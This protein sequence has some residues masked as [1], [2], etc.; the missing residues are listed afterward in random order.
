MSD[1]VPA[2]PSADEPAAAAAVP[3]PAEQVVPE[4]PVAV[5]PP[6][7]PENLVRGLLLSLITIP[8]GIVVFSVIYNLG[9]I[10]SIVALGVAFAAFF[11]YRLGSGGRVSMRGAVVVAL[12]TIVTLVLAFIVAQYTVIAVALAGVWGI[13][14]V[15]V[16]TSPEFPGIAGEILA[17][18]TVSGE[19]AGDAVFTFIFGLLGCGAI[20]FNVFRAA[21]A[22]QKAATAA[23][24]AP[25][26][27]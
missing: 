13:S 21:R 4:T 14:W 18:P 17:D 3:P 20:L 8:V 12:V 24:E 16:L 23:P 9:F 26:A 22:E 7:P 5:A 1:Q 11:L 2:I 19:V 6:L 10:A 15:E 27:V 25:P